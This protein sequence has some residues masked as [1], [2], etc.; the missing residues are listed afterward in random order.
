MDALVTMML[1]AG[2]S[3]LNMALY[4]LLP[5]MVIMLAFMRLLDAKGL[6][7]WVCHQPIRCCGRGNFCCRR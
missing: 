7:T 3:G 4:I 5:I 1:D 2:K 6:L